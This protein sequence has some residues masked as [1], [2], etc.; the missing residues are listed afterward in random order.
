MIEFR[1]QSESETLAF[2]RAVA[3]TLAVGDVVGL[4][5]ELG[6]GKTRLAA[7]IIEGL[8][9]PDEVTSPT[10]SLIHEHRGRVPVAHVDAY[11]LRNGDELLSLGI[12][13]L[14]E[15][16]VVIIEWASRVEDVLPSARLS[17]RGET[18]SPGE[19][20]W[21]A[22]WTP[23]AGHRQSELQQQ[24]ADSVDASRL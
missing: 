8:G 1:T 3:E 17:I 4:D 14:W 11:R 5:G 20:I 9:C 6:T 10:F 22:S 13:E 21:Q 18:A 7:G 16:G 23:A 19:R 12:S 15:D 2:G 24:F